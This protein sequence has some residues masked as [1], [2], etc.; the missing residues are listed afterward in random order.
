MKKNYYKHLLIFIFTLFAL[1]SATYAEGFKVIVLGNHGGPRENNIS[2]YLIAP[3]EANNF[4]SLDAGSLLHGIYLA[5]KKNSFQEITINSRNTLDVETEILQNH[6][7]GYLIS[8]AHLDHIAG[9]ILNSTADTKKPIFGIDSTIDFIRDH[10][11][12]WRIW[13]NFG[14]EGKNPRLNQYQYHRLKPK[15][16]IHIPDTDFT[17]EPFL[18]SH[19]DCCPSTAFLLEA[20]GLYV[21]YFGDTSPDSL[22]SKNHMETIWKRV[23]PLIRQNKLRGIFLECSYSQEETELFGHL[24]SKYMIE[25]LSTLANFVNPKSP[26]TA[27][28]GLTIIVTHIKGARVNGITAT[29]S[30]QQELE[31]LNTLGVQFIFPEQGEKI[32]L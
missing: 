28:T 9:L 8:H 13:P 23:A 10:L 17:V 21:L 6:I 22:E 11:F 4:I 14:S 1:N 20:F 3:N 31:T 5:H 24:N 7:K 19:L 25:E 26:Q 18:L 15:K 2:G 32:Q 16:K 27:L 12:N 30:I 29:Q